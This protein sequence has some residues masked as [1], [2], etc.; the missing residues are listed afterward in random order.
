MKFLPLVL[1]L[2]AGTGAWFNL[3][4][5]NAGQDKQITKLESDVDEQNK[6][7]AQISISQATLQ[8]KV[9]SSYELL[10][11]LKDSIKEISTKK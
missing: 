4:S 8:S 5:S 7:Y 11:D 3:N 2:F 9:D 6:A 1:V 10:K